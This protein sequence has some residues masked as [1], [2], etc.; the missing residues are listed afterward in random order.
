MSFAESGVIVMRRRGTEIMFGLIGLIRPLM[1]IMM[2]AILLGI[3]GFLAAISIVSLS[4]YAIIGY[5][6]FVDVSIKK[7]L[8]IICVCAVLRGV[9][10]YGEQACNHLIAFKLLAIIRRNVFDAL[11]RLAPAKVEGKDK[12]EL[13]SV[14][15]SDIELLEVFYAHTVSPVAIAFCTCTIMTAVLYQYH[16]AFALIGAL[17]Y[18]TIGVIIPLIMGKIGAK[19][20]MNYRENFSSLNGKLFDTLMGVDEILQYGFKKQ[21]YE[22]IEKTEDVLNEY[23]YKLRGLEGIQRGV[24]SAMI[25]LFGILAL[26]AGVVMYDG[27]IVNYDAVLMP[28]LILLSSFGPVVALSNL[29]NNLNQTLASGERVMRILEEQPETEDVIGERKAFFGDISVDNISFSYDR[30]KILD[31]VS[32]DIG[33]HE[34]LGI[35]GKSGS[36]KSTLL[37]L[38]MRFWR[39]NDGNISINSRNID[40]INTVQLRKMQSYVTQETWI[41]NDTIANNIGIAN[42]HAGLAEIKKAAKKAGIHE[43]IQALPKGYDTNAGE[44]GDFLSGGERQR[45]G[46]ARAFLHD[47]PMMILDEPTSN[48]DSLNENHILKSIDDEKNNRTVIMVSHRQSTMA[49]AQKIYKMDS[50]RMS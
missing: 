27:Y 30:E 29:S 19:A 4:G 21:Q 37:K 32:L 3:L 9:L 6:G 10:H 36:G 34:V 48:L 20:G 7:V 18:F 41:F 11:R 2:L 8:V 12:G 49:I 13:V 14:L 24:T 42:L 33:E 28:V 1:P 40:E 22:K 50:G 35:H 23:A 17:G 44:L 16:I 38:I 15:T 46:L 26:T 5:M 39:V 25:L 31:E 47:A 45:I 43:F